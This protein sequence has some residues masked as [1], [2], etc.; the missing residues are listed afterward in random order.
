MTDKLAKNLSKLQKNIDNRNEFFALKSFF[1]FLSDIC[2]SVNKPIVL[3]I[4]EVDNAA[5]NQVFMK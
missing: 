2:E 5:D 1:F 3:M 4:D